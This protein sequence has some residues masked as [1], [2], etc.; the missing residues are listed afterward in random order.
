MNAETTITTKTK[1][2]QI[3]QRIR[4][5]ILK[6]EAAP[7]EKLVVHQL[8]KH[9]NTSIIPVREALGRLEAQDLVTVVPHTGIYVKGIDI[10]RLQELYPIRG[11]LEGFA[12]RLATSRLTAA[13][14]Q[15][16]RALIDQ[17]DGAIDRPDPAA[18][19][20][21][22]WQF[23]MAIYN[24][25]G[26]QTLV[27]MIDDL[28]QKTIMARLIFKLTPKRAKAA[29]REHRDILAALEKGKAQNA[30][31]LIIRQGEKTLAL[32]RRQLDGVESTK[33][34]CLDPAVEVAH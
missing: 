23:H 32:L 34:I 25:C 33:G 22:N 10:A 17:M 26:N 27:R 5:A 14:F 11:I 29:N 31:K 16:L 12:T 2:D 6:G 13:H 20:E 15:Q 8:A 19:G 9:F 7:G 18:M 21:L 30:E 3:H 1:A 28:W 24:A 4:S